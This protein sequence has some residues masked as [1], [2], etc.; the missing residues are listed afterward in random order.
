MLLMDV[1]VTAGWVALHWSVEKLTCDP[2]AVPAE[3]VA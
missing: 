2:Y 3:L 1:V